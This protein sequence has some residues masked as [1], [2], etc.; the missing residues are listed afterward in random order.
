MPDDASNDAIFEAA[1]DA[2]VDGDLATLGRLL[3]E[4]PGLVRARSS[5]A[6]R[7][8]LL[9]YV[10]ANG[11]EDFRQKTPANIVDVT[12]TLLDAGAEVDAGSR[13]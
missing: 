10:S 6:H 12:R 5:R 2:I 4:N 13:S 1:A 3:S 9:H 11:V 8:T 7:A